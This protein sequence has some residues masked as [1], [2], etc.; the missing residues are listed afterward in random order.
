[1]G[2]HNSSLTRVQP[3]FNQLYRFDPSGTHWLGDLLSLG[4]RVRAGIVRLPTDP[5]QWPG[6]LQLP[7][8]YELPVAAPLDYLRE[9]IR[10]PDRLQESKGYVGMGAKLSHTNDRRREVVAGYPDT[11]SAAIENLKTDRVPGR[12]KWWVL[13]GVT[14][15]DCLLHAEHVNAFIEGKR[16]ENHLTEST[17]WDPK[18]MQ[19]YRN[20]DCLRAICAP[21]KNFYI[22]LVVE[23]GSAA[24]HA[25]ARLDQNLTVARESWPHL[26]EEQ[27]NELYRRYLGVTTWQMIA[28]HFGAQ[29]ELE[30]PDD[31]RAAA[32]SGLS[33]P[34]VWL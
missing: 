33:G 2:E 27:A 1:M 6:R 15:V 10:S 16:K 7:P 21:R 23:N 26:N 28:E 30:F 9:L 14:K 11:C 8:Q 31:V 5:A 24:H 18:R 19:V 22:L 12:G 4:S 32:E 17:E 3:V 20:L 25:A 34:S 29:V 13:E